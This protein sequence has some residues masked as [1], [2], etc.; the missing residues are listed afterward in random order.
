MNYKGPGIYRHYKGGFYRVLG[1]AVREETIGTEEE[2][3]EVVYWP[4]KRYERK[5]A[6]VTRQLEDFNDNAILVDGPVVPRFQKLG[7]FR[8]WVLRARKRHWRE[9]NTVRFQALE[10][11]ASLLGEDT[12]IDTLTQ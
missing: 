8:A 1:L 6:F 2:I 5:E 12:Y 7:A 9:G 4:L 10:F 11:V 3:S